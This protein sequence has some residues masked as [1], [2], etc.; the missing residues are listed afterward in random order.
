VPIVRGGV[1][2]SF[3]LK[4]Y[5]GKL[6]DVSTLKTTLAEVFSLGGSDLTL[7]MDKGFAS[8]DNINCL[9][10]GPMKNNF[11]MAL[12][13]TMELAKQQPKKFFD[14]IKIPANVIDIVPKTWGLTTMNYLNNGTKVFVHTYYN[15]DKAISEEYEKQTEIKKLMEEAINN[16]ES[17]KNQKDFKKWLN[18]VKDKN[19]K[20]MSVEVKQKELEKALAYSGWLVV[21][22]NREYKADKVLSIYRSK[23]VVEKSFHRLKAQLGMCRLRMHLD[24][25]MRSKIFVSFLSLIMFSYI[26]KVMLDKDMYKKYTLKELIDI[27]ESLHVIRIRNKIVLE[28][29]TSELKVIFEAF[30]IDKPFVD[31]LTD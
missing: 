20:V 9:T 30:N 11:I 2:A 26:N 16:P 14:S 18:I 10:T 3:I 7:V 29:L 22:S 28:P 4:P 17:K 23:D 15:T 19:G 8:D 12:P 27:M 13:F 25:T 21:I 1:T 31:K 6:K 5:H 24:A